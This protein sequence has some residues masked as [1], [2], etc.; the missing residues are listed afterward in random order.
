[1]AGASTVLLVM[2]SMNA[3]NQLNSD[4]VKQSEKIHTYNKRLIVS[5]TPMIFACLVKIVWDTSYEVGC[6]IGSC[7]TMVIGTTTYYNAK[8]FA[9]NYNTP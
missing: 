4:F 2:W 6:G 5:L 7:D 9:C 1:M 3:K 8:Y